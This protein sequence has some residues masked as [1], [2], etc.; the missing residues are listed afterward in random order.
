MKMKFA[1]IHS[2]LLYGLDDGAKT[3]DETAL[4]LEDAAKNS[5]DLIVCTPHMFPGVKPFDTELMNKR[6]EEARN[7]CAEKGLDITLLPGAEVLCSGVL[8]QYML[9]HTLPTLG[10]TGCIL[11]EFMPDARYNEIEEC[12]KTLFRRHGYTVIIAHAERYICLRGGD[13]LKK[14][15]QHTGAII[16][17][18]ASTLAE[19]KN[20]LLRFLVCRW[21]KQGLVDVIASDAHNAT[22]RGCKMK[23]AY[24]YIS[25]KLGYETAMEL[26][27][28]TQDR[29]GLTSE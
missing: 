29:L 22:F 12:V 13:R 6:L 17:V 25:Q 14:L 15:R 4:M 24:D 11:I 1:E 23:A 3:R 7:I 20:P 27:S 9:E 19:S 18:N 5:V 26:C 10:G 21:I 16:Q 8:D 2:H 28:I